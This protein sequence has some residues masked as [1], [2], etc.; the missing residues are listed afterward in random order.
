MLPLELL[1]HIFSYLNFRDVAVCGSVSVLWRHAQTVAFEPWENAQKKLQTLYDARVHK[2]CRLLYQ[3]I[4]PGLFLV[5]KLHHHAAYNSCKD[6]CHAFKHKAWKIHRHVNH[7]YSPVLASCFFEE[8]VCCYQGKL[9]PYCA[10]CRHL[11]RAYKG[12]QLEPTH[13]HEGEG[14]G[15]TLVFICSNECL[16]HLHD[17]YPHFMHK[18]TNYNEIKFF[19]LKNC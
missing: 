19:S 8:V 18:V 2:K 5:V 7:R 15:P 6:W 14:F 9:M 1:I 13:Y 17:T 16:T 12:Q 11:V 3:D 10:G 4:C